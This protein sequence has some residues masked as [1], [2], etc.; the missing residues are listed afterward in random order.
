MGFGIFLTFSPS[1]FQTFPQPLIAPFS[2]SASPS[3]FGIWTLE[4]GNFAPLPCSV[5]FVAFCS[6]SPPIENRKF[7]PPPFQHFSFSAFQRFPSRSPYGFGPPQAD[8]IWDF[9]PPPAPHAHPRSMERPAALRGCSQPRRGRSLC[10]GLP[11]A[12]PHFTGIS[13]RCRVKR[14]FWSKGNVPRSET[15]RFEGLTPDSFF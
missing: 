14:T 4:F 12:V 1:H 2:I 11:T 6:K 5:T 10:G 13:P 9:H 8:G 7:Q 3:P 15:G